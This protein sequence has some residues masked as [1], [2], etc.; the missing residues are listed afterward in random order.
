MQKNL[1]HLISA[2]LPTV[3][4]QWTCIG[5]D[6]GRENDLFTGGNAFR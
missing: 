3:K 6:S 5:M 4:Y 2:I 1:L